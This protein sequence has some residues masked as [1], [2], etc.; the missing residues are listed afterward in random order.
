MNSSA[1]YTE[2][3]VETLFKTLDTGN[4]GQIYYTEFLAAT[5]EA[6]G[7]IVEETLADA[8]DRMDSDDT[9]FISVQNL[10]DFLGKDS[11]EE[12]VIKLMKEAD[13]DGDGRISF[14]E[15][16]TS[17]RNTQKIAHRGLIM[18]DDDSSIE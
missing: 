17:F 1:S 11:S 14:E 7:R 15:F 5:L 18:D 16:L 9:G 8:F 4:D 13:L 6:H 3:D 12:K 10:R 2:N